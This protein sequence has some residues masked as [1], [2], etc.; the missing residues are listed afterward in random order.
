MKKRV[1]NLLVIASVACLLV[2]NVVVLKDGN[3]IN[4]KWGVLDLVY[5]SGSG[6]S[7][8]CT[9]DPCC[10]PKSCC[11]GTVYVCESDLDQLADDSDSNCCPSC[12]AV[13]VETYPC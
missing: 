10:E 11:T 8:G 4:L 13:Q 1:I 12:S 5:A 6:S 2:L 3:A 9:D 7:G